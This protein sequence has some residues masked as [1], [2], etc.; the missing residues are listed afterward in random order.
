MALDRSLPA[1]AG[2]VL[3][4]VPA[5]PFAASAPG[6]EPSVAEPPLVIEGVT[7]V[8]MESSERVLADHT[9][10][11]AG[12]RIAALGPAGSVA[13]PADAVRV[14]GRGRWLVPGLTDM[15]C[16]LLAD[17]R[18]AE[19]FAPDELAV[20]LANGVT[21]FRDPIGVPER[22]VTRDRVGRGELLGPRHFVGS[23]QLAG[24]PFGKVFHGA[25][26][27]DA[28]A[29]R[30][31]VRR[32][33]A[34]GYDGIKLTLFITPEVFDA[35]IDEGKKLGIPIFGHVG[36]AVGLPR[37]LAAGMQIEHLDQYL[38]ELL[39]D[40]SPKRESLSD[41]GIYRN[42]DTLPFLDEARIPALARS[43]AAAG[44]WST[45]TSAFLHTAFGRG[46][47]DAE[48][49]RDPDARFVSSEVRADLLAGRDMYDTRVNPSREERERWMHLRNEIV[50]QVHAAGG[51]ILAGS[52]CPEWMLLYGF[53]LHREL[54]FLVEAGLT[55]YAALE[56]ATKNP[57]E[58]MGRLPDTGTV[59]TGKRADLVLL[60]ANPL[61]DIGATRSIEG[62][63]AGGR[64]LPRKE[65]DGMLARAAERLSKA[66]LRPE[67]KE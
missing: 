13:V 39:T 56:A 4:L 62:V 64:W 31:A 18:I 26:V 33:H 19:E 67:R 20:I 63:V 52:D 44:V 10:L 1:L 53:T 57:A 47:P 3:A 15:H 5:S 45:P 34:E 38:E 59:S 14:D 30:E 43:V 27:K 35:I 60:A 49:D 66:P 36:P 41:V 28:A 6:P 42:W 54:A 11:V 25:E 51:K 16:H 12:G 37:A 8:T 23:P 21:T 32:F 9:V 40:E 2:L 50:R 48:I 65:L 22:L 55:P 58:W 17:D 61:E 29:G 24:R 7:V 46:R